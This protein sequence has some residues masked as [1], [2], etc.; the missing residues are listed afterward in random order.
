MRLAHHEEQVVQVEHIFQNRKFFYESVSNS[1]SHLTF[2]RALYFLN[3]KSAPP[4]KATK[5]NM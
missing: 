3:V 4:S 1:S 5:A 2:G